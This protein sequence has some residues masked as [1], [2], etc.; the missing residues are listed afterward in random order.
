MNLKKT[1]GSK[2]FRLGTTLVVPFVLQI[3]TTVGLVWF[4]TYRSGQQ[5][6]TD[7]ASQLRNELTNRIIGKLDSYTDTPEPINRLNAGALQKGELNITNPQGQ[8]P[9]WQQMEIYPTISNVYCGDENGSFLGVGRLNDRDRSELS[10]IYSNASTNFQ[11]Q[12]LVLDE[13]GNAIE[14][15]NTTTK[16]Y[17][18][19]SRPWYKVAKAAG[20]SV[21]SEVYLS[22]STQHP[23]ITA[24][25][26][27][28]NRNNGSL[29]GVCATD[30]Y[31]PE[32]VNDFL[33]KL[34][35]GKTGTAFIIERSGKLVA[36]ASA[37]PTVKIDLTGRRL[38]ATKSN[39]PIVNG[40][41]DSLRDRFDNFSQIESV[42][43][44]VLKINGQKQYVQVVPF[45]DDNLDWLVVLTIPEADFMSQI[46]IS[47][48]NSLLFSAVALAMAIAIGV[49]TSRWVAKPILRVSHAA[50]ELAKGDLDQQVAP[51]PIIEINALANSFNSMARQLKNSFTNLEQNNERLRIAEENYRSIFENALEGIFQYSPEGFYLSVN[52]ALA[53]IYG[54]ES[55]R[56]MIT[57]ITNIGEQI[58]VD[59]PKRAEFRQLL[60]KQDEVKNFE[61]RC[62]C[63]NKSW[64]WIQVD[65]RVVRDNRGKV[66]YYEGI[67][68]DISDRK[69]REAELKRQLQQLKVEIDQTMREQEVARLTK[70][71]YFQEVRQEI[72]QM[73]LDEFWS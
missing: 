36:T 17:D 31:L 58:Y 44:I 26:P 69:R 28:Y 2:K 21:W 63:K 22:L 49:F 10:L 50:D 38:L 13:Q 41:A 52:P 5:A 4:I 40:I 54:Y 7:A 39:D 14:Q 9:F 6:V 42:R 61:Y 32:E 35:I 56:E 67:V 60:T 66:L 20:R 51:S 68:Q 71:S 64:I 3:F 18:P 37:E 19:G 11:R 12:Y 48:R 73:D 1:Y 29:I 45:Q 8:H 34:R 25:V 33:R 62:Y 43:Q 23:T 15:T 70:N 47:R 53:K 65:A 27:V 72:A 24:T 16:P 30:F 55:P 46:H 59:P 57:S